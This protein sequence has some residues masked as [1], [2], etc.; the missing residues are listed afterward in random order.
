MSDRY[1]SLSGNDSNDGL[2]GGTTWRTLA[3][4]AS[5]A[6]AGMT[7]HVAPGDYAERVNVSAS[8]SSGSPI[9]FQGAGWTSIC[10]GFNCTGSY[11]TINDFKIVNNGGT[12]HFDRSGNSG[13]N[14]TASNVTVQR[15]WMYQT[16]ACGVY[17]PSSASYATIR[18]CYFQEVMQCASE[19][20][21]HHCLFE[22]CTIDNVRN[23]YVTA[24]TDVDAFII[25]G[26]DNTIQ[27]CL[28]INMT[29]SGQKGSPHIDFAQTWGQG[30]DVYNWTFQR[31][32]IVKN[33]T[34]RDQCFTFEAING[35][36]HDM[37]ILNN[38]VV[39]YSP[40][41][42]T[43]NPAVYIGQNAGDPYTLSNIEIRGNTFIAM[44]T[45]IESAIEIRPSTS[46]IT[47]ADNYVVNHQAA[48]GWLRNVSNNP[49]TI[50]V[51]NNTNV[52]NVTQKQGSESGVTVFAESSTLD[53][54]GGGGGQ[55]GIYYVDAVN[56]SN[57]NDGTT[58]AT[59]KATINAGVGLLAAGD[60]LIVRAGTY[61]ERLNN[62]TIPS[63]SGVSTPTTIKA[64]TGESPTMN[65]NVW[66]S[67]KDNIVWDGININGI[68]NGVPNADGGMETYTNF[69][70]NGGTNILVKNCEIYNASKLSVLTHDGNGPLHN[71][72]FRNCKVHDPGQGGWT[73]GNE[74][75]NHNFYLS[76]Y[77]GN[78]YVGPVIVDGCEIYNA[79]GPG[80]NSWGMQC[81]ASYSGYL[82]GF[83]IRNNY[84]H[85]N[86]QG[87]AVGC[88]PNHQV[89]NN[90]FY[91]N[92]LPGSYNEAAITVGYGSGM[93][94]IQVY[95]NTIVDN[96][97][98]YGI[99]VGTYGSPT[100]TLIKNNILWANGVDNINLNAGT[101]TVTSN[102]LMGQD[103]LFEQG[104]FSV[105]SSSPAKGMG[106][107]LTSV[108]TTDK[109]GN[110]RPA[111]GAWDAGA[112][113]VQDSAPGVTPVSG[114]DYVSLYLNGATVPVTVTITNLTV[115]AD[116]AIL[117]VANTTSNDIEQAGTIFKTAFEVHNMTLNAIGWPT[118]TSGEYYV[119][120][121][122][123]LAV[124]LNDGA[125][126]FSM[127]A[128]I[129]G[130][131]TV[132][133]GLGE[134]VK[135]NPFHIKIVIHGKTRT[136]CIEVELV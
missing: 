122:D 103:P 136:K 116:D 59:A 28:E 9:I 20:W 51:T 77:G 54:G 13:V 64:Y 29:T 50:S 120:G 74:P 92:T 112:Y 75:A 123:S 18:D 71:I 5:M 113:I 12:N 42:R 10:K 130:A 22:R 111:A 106:V 89:Y 76:G 118:I 7:I 131:D 60:T 121:Y 58:A 47:I 31:N 80:P 33:G 68:N 48:S 46:N 62:N 109:A 90:V 4:A 124:G 94:N 11:I 86:L 91:Q 21:A 36:T 73:S 101:G 70:I 96:P 100:N 117:V 99:S 24:T 83:I 23:T 39:S 15:C 65:G 81:Y 72:E 97:G 56:G 128:Q 110:T 35:P 6:V 108:F 66:I 27:D 132:D 44:K 67:T 87:L 104:L 55:P 53:N 25:A 1:V 63:G 49:G 85:D 126:I 115:T 17:L 16:H 43:Y 40:D 127:T 14:I 30:G 41:N 38:V 8:G 32:Y 114:S 52:T 26:H 102:N 84:F 129:N 78:G 79:L 105:L 125:S 95:N 88:G 57:S 3:K 45:I 119:Y 98:G 37:H 61:N 19:I 134:A 82:D 34:G 107:N 133:V 93:S 135:R 69:F 2:T